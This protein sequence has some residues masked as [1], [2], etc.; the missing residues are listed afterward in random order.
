MEEIS[1]SAPMASIPR[2]ERTI[3]RVNRT[4]PPTCGAEMDS[5][6]T[7]RCISPIFLPDKNARETAAV[8]TPMP[9]N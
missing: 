2:D 6:I 1:S 7:L 5:C 8:T 9:P 3:K 4:M